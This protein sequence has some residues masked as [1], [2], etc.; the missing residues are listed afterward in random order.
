M[1]LLK[2]LKL[3]IMKEPFYRST[4][5]LHSV[6]SVG[7]DPASGF[8]ASLA[9][10][11]KGRE[12]PG[13]AP[14]SEPFS[15]I[16]KALPE[17][18]RHM[19]FSRSARMTGIATDDI[20]QLKAEDFARAV[21]DMYP[22]RKYPAIMIG[23]ASGAMIH[24][25]AAMGIPFLP[26]T[27]TI[28]VARPSYLPVDEPKRNME[29]ALEPGE[30]FLQNNADFKLHHIF[31][32][33]HN[34]S[35]LQNSSFFKIKMQRLV[36]EYERFIAQ[37]LEKGGTIIISDCTRQWPVSMI[38]DRFV[39]QFGAPGS[40]SEEDYFS[41]SGQ[42]SQYLER[43][44]S[45][46]RNWDAPVSDGEQ[47]EAEWGFD[48]T[49]LSDI[50]SVSFI[51]GFKTFKISFEDPEHPS[52]FVAELYRWWYQQKGVIVNRLVAE[53][54]IVHEPYW[55]LR[56]GSVPF[57]L[58]SDSSSSAQWLG[59][60]LGKTKPYDE[61]FMM[62]HSEGMNTL[63]AASKERWNEILQKAEKKHDYIGQEEEGFQ[64]G[65]KSFMLSNSDLKKK[66]LSRYSFSIPLSIDQLLEFKKTEIF[67]EFNDKIS[68]ETEVSKVFEQARKSGKAEMKAVKEKYKDL[69]DD[70]ISE[71]QNPVAGIEETGMSTG[72]SE[73]PA[74][75]KGIDE[76]APHKRSMREDKPNIPKDE[77]NAL[78]AD[79]KIKSF[80]AEPGKPL[81][82]S[83]ATGEN[84]END[85]SEDENTS[86]L[87]GSD[88]LA[89]KAK[90]HY[91]QPGGPGAGSQHKSPDNAREKKDESRPRTHKNKNKKKR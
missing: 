60:Y 2:K 37:N 56:T 85:T 5:I 45:H 90:P 54:Y 78:N 63:N 27:F 72:P 53:N 23:S 18:V 84:Q 30:T 39:F 51:N 52:P 20:G 21:I 55:N 4:G 29:W 14:S 83:R 80:K 34:R 16:V 8:V 12:T 77:L 33:V 26:Q 17:K 13:L 47:A 75:E 22:A 32:P 79:Q 58:K 24:L 25:A 46:V 3:N 89:P 48:Y 28:P 91:S 66:I 59:E 36:L 81:E 31:D 19:L 42:V 50:E 67:N 43:N 64:A 61:I 6:F 7:L 40:A 11:L 10:A 69:K 44:N 38:N 70:L 62:L 82:Y 65:T 35:D 49:L 76:S 68:V 74:S 57:W 15:T 41:G 87:H 9:N 86:H 88:P 71:M 73:N 1:N